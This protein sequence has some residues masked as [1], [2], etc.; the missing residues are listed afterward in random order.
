MTPPKSVSQGPEQIKE[1]RVFE[2]VVGSGWDRD[3]EG[4]EA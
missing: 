1:T 4:R 2:E 3:E